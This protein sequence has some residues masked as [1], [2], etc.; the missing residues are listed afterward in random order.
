MVKYVK[1]LLAVACFYIVLR[2]CFPISNVC[3]DNTSKKLDIVLSGGRG[4]GVGSLQ[5]EEL[6][7]EFGVLFLPCWVTGCA[8]GRSVTSQ[9]DREA[10]DLHSLNLATTW[11]TGLKFTNGAHRTQRGCYPGGN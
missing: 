7:G 11:V 3:V 4:V 10:S 8:A 6:G 9:G 2:L 1:L 5:L